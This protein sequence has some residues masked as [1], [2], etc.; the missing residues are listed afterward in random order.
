MSV[1]RGYGNAIINGIF[2]FVSL[3]GLPLKGLLFTFQRYLLDQPYPHLL[4][5]QLPFHC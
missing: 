1:Q 5:Q 3:T 4:I 2:P